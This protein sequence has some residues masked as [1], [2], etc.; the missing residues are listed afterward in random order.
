MKRTVLIIKPDAVASG[1]IGD[2]LSVVEK[3]GFRPVQLKMVVLDRGAAARLYA[4]H[5]GKTFF[6]SLLEF[7]TGGPVVV[8]VLERADAVNR[9]RELLGSTDSREAAPGTIRALYGRNEQ[10]NA[11]HGSDSPESAE[12]ESEMF[13]VDGK[14]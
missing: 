10:M 7:M 13:F 6:G 3:D 12:R 5:E 14:P 2:I 11:A 9:L 8:C 1:H 4:P